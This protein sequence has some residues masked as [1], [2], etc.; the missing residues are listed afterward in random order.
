MVYQM[1]KCLYNETILQK[2]IFDQ[3]RNVL[4]HLIKENNGII[5]IDTYCYGLK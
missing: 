4:I 1:P 2:K 3:I 5:I